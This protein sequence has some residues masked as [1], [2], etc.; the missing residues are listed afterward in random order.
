MKKKVPVKINP[1]GLLKAVGTRQFEQK[2]A[3]QGMTVQEYKRYLEAMDKKQRTR[4]PMK[5]AKFE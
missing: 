4:D 5:K 1:K 2:A 3:A